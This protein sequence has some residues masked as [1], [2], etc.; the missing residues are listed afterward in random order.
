MLDMILVLYRS[1]VIPNTSAPI[2]NNEEW[3]VRNIPFDAKLTVAIYDKDDDK[4]NDDYIGRFVI[5]DLINYT[6]PSNGHKIIDAS[7]H[8][9]GSFYLLIQSMRSSEEI[10]HLPRYTFDGP[11]RYSRHDSLVAGHLNMLNADCIYSI[12]KIQL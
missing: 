5:N 9:N 1:S 6:P 10:K 11:C 2:W 12:W 8:N 4:I 3:I 7:G